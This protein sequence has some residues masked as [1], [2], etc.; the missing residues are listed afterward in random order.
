MNGVNTPPGGPGEFGL[1]AMPG[2]EGEFV[3]AMELALRYAQALGAGTIHVMSGCPP[4]D[5]AGQARE[6]FLRNLERASDMAAGS[7]VSLLVE[8]INVRD[9][10]GY[11]V[12][13]SDEVA[14]LLRELGREN[15]KMMLDLYH[16]Q[17]MEGDL[18]T[19]L[20]RHWPLIGHIQFASVQRRAEPDEGEI[21]WGA[22][23]EA[24]AERGWQ[25]YVAAEYRPRG[26][27]LDGLAWLAAARA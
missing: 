25:G 9:R 26:A 11:F 10:P 21:A 14:V 12:S 5:A 3:R 13:R 4:H 16:V 6:V 22:I 8:P 27:T 20:D 17:I 1:A 19:R 2:R 15:V 24:I 7:G 18:L 23:F